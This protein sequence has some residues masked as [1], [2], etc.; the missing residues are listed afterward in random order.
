[1]TAK[2]LSHTGV[3]ANQNIFAVLSAADLQV[4]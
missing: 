2:S 3:P 1:M 4:L